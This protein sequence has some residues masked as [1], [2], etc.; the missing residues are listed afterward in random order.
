MLDITDGKGENMIKRISNFLWVLLL[1]SLVMLYSSDSFAR[2][3]TNNPQTQISLY[4]SAAITTRSLTN[5]GNWAYIYMYDGVSAFNTLTNGSG[6]TYPRGTGTAIYR[7]GLVW[8]GLVQD[9]DPDKPKLRVGGNT[10]RSG[11]QPGWYGGDPNDERAYIYRI[12][13]DWATL[14]HS[15][16]IQDAAEINGV[17]TDEVTTSMTDAVIAQYK[18]DW[19]NWPVDLGAPY[20]DVDENGEYNPVLDDNGMPISAEYDD[21]GNLI[22][23]GDYP[24]IAQADQVLWFVINDGNAGRVNDLSG[25][26]PIG[27]EVQTTSWAYN[28]PTSGLGQIV[29]KKYKI[30]NKSG[31]R[32]DSMYVCQ[33]C[34]P[35][36]GNYGDDLTGCDTTLSLMFAY[37]GFP[38]DGTYDAY[39]LAPPAVGYDFFQGPIVPSPGDTAVFDLKKVPD[40]KNLPITSYGYFGSG[41]KWTDPTM[42][43]YDGTL[44][45]Y[46]LLRGFAPT[47]DVDSVT[48][49]VHTTGPNEGENTKFPLDGDPVTG[50]GDVDGV[51]YQPGDR[52]MLQSTGPFVMEN[53][54]VQEVVV[55][56]VGGLGGNNLQSVADMKSTDAVAQVVYNS[57]FKVIPKPPSAPL[58]KANAMESQIVL[59][60]GWNQAAV[61]KTENVKI[62]GYEFEGYNIYQLPSATASIHD[63]KSV[64]VATFDRINGVRIIKSSMFSPEYGTV[65]ALPVQFGND[66][67]VKRYFI[68]EKDYINNLPL[69]R[70][71]TYYFAVTAYNYDGTL[72]RD[73]ALESAG[74][75]HAI[76][77]AGPPPG[78]EYEGNVGEELKVDHEGVS[79][80]QVQVVVVDPSTTTGHDYEIFFHVDED[81]NSATYGDTFWGL[82]DKTSG[83][84]VTKK[85]EQ[86]LDLSTDD[87][88]TFDGLLI[89]VA[90]PALTMKSFQVVTNGDGPVDPPASA[91]ASW[92]G[93]PVPDPDYNIWPN[94]ANGSFWFVH[95]WPNGSRASFDAF[96]A[97]TFA[98]TGGYGVAGGEG[99]HNLIPHDFEIRF[100]GAGKAFDNW[101]TGTVLNVPFEL[102]DIGDVND[103]GDDYKLMPYLYDYDGNGAFNLMYDALDPTAD[104]GWAD[105]ETS[106]ALNDPWTDPFYWMHPTDNTPGTQGFDNMVAA[107]ESDPSGAAA[108]YSQPGWASGAYDAWAGMHRMVLVNWN[109]GDVTTATSPA[110]YNAEMPD[111]GAVFRLLTTKPNT[112]NDKF[113]F[114]APQVSHSTDQ[115]QADVEKINVF[116]NPYYGDNPQETSRFNRFVTFNHLPKRAHFRIFNLAGVMVRKREK[117][118]D[119]QFFKWDLLN[120]RGLPVASGVYIVHI[121]MPDLSKEKVLKVFIVQAKQILEYY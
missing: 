17:T 71:S 24:G 62:I 67:G 40:H 82:Y 70:G 91:A 110:D 15:A 95:T 65:V 38:T 29:F 120:D 18:D 5:I 119:S 46:N 104:P 9:P 11:T 6:G 43:T 98:Y 97:R 2:E 78:Y 14:T 81:T 86:L 4:K 59:D 19:K 76:T 112:V 39:N 83:D 16:V 75:A 50:E 89:K 33:W 41:T 114:T 35:D 87:A 102:W 61:E 7:D 56:V 31:F 60:W 113:V 100:T 73:R 74:T 37:N 58:V 52:R 84:T 25:S 101:N 64:R 68:V 34:D 66:T 26:P 85:R 77:V 115:E 27:L 106:S 28:Q 69:Y 79:D 108:W 36:V 99:I 92:Q 121:D 117:D 51:T 10:Y 80:G 94:M 30:I 103:A 12:R 54:D 116:P 63:P 45:W 1:G 22:A 90:G 72:I 3:N 13:Q 53:N 8:G 42:G 57:L 23:G 109:G 49:F 21:D 48:W 105:H 47:T 118:D 32:I 107:L 20:Y 44:Q 88:L 55:A 93:F 111:D 96:M